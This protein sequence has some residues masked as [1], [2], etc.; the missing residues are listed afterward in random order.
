MALLVKQ[1]ALEEG[2]AKWGAEMTGV[3][4]QQLIYDVAESQGRNELQRKIIALEE[5]VATTMDV[6]RRFVERSLIKR[7]GGL[8]LDPPTGLSQL[9]QDNLAIAMNVEPF[10]RLLGIK[11]L[12][13]ISQSIK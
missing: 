11:L 4:L 8:L 1:W 12:E 13:L 2:I 6:D 5:D 3:L 10:R 9:D 7:A